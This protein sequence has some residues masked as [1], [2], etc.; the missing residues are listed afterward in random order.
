MGVEICPKMEFDPLPKYLAK[1]CRKPMKFQLAYGA[2]I[3]KILGKQG[4]SFL[5]RFIKFVMAF[6]RGE[7]RAN[8]ISKYCHKDYCD[9]GIFSAC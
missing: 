5:L 6:Y 8:T 2:G 1:V 4:V 3:R 9:K 7:F